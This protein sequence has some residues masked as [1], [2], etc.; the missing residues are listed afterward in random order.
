MKR[1]MC[2]L[3]L[4]AVAAGSALWLGGISSD[5]AAQLLTQAVNDD[6]ILRLHIVASSDTAADQALKLKVRD[7]VLETT[8]MCL[9]GVESAGEASRAV[10]ASLEAIEESAAQTARDNGFTGDVAASLGRGE[11]P[12]RIYGGVRVPAG[13]Y[14]AL[15]ISLGEGAGANWWCVIYPS[16]CFE[17]DGAITLAGMPKKITFD[18]AILKWLR[19]LMKKSG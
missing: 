9:A 15:R 4:L 5:D 18:S 13:T 12:E 17:K 1:M 11:F 7:A 3:L 6:D 2:A 16:L 8:R 19:K 14:N 10:Q